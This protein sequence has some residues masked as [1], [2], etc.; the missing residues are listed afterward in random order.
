MEEDHVSAFVGKV[1]ILGTL[2]QEEIARA[3]A[4]DDPQSHLGKAD[5]LAAALVQ[6]A[7][8]EQLRLAQ[9]TGQGAL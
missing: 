9:D 4:G 2:L 3:L 5:E 6:A 1:L 8:E 7:H